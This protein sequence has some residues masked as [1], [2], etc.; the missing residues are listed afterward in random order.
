MMMRKIACG[1][2][3]SLALMFAVP[4][5]AQNTAPLQGNWLGNG[6][7][8]QGGPFAVSY[9][10]HGNSTTLHGMIT[11]KHNIPMDSTAP[12]SYRR[13]GN[14]TELLSETTSKNFKFVLRTTSEAGTL[15]GTM[16]GIKIELN[17]GP[18]SSLQQY[19]NAYANSCD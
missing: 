19:Y 7:F 8:G 17:R 4:A 3:L 10:I 1:V 15:L 6:C 9:S 12:A 16:N 18:V 14:Q 2:G 11:N 5:M 13:V